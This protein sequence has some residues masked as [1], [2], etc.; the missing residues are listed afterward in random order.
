[1]FKRTYS[2]T[3]LISLYSQVEQLTADLNAER[4]NTQKKKIFIA[5]DVTSLL[6]YSF[7][8]PAHRLSNW[9][10]IWTPS[11]PTYRR[12]RTPVL[13]SSEATK[14]WRLSLWLKCAQMSLLNYSF[15]LPTYRLS[16]SLP[17]W[18]LSAPT[19]RRPRTPDL[20]SSEAT[21]RWRLSWAKWRLK[22]ARVAKPRLRHWRARLAIWRSSWMLKP[23][24]GDRHK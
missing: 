18:T 17:T 8:Y 22:C 12:P 24:N 10:L 9:L 19:S 3:L 6:T 20:P 15:L 11:A 2:F 13:P 23:G 7:L 14:R 1:M 5:N 21:K 16:N 4:T